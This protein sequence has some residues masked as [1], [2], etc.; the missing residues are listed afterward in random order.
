VI[1]ESSERRKPKGDRA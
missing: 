1:C